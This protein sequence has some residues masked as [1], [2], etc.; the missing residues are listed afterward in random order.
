MRDWPE[1]HGRA[2]L[3]R[4][5]PAAQFAVE[6]THLALVR[7]TLQ[8]AGQC[9]RDGLK[10]GKWQVAGGA[11][12]VR[13]R[14]LAVPSVAR[15]PAEVSQGPLT[16]PLRLLQ[17]EA[18][19]IVAGEG[20]RPVALLG[21]GRSSSSAPQATARPAGDRRLAASRSVTH[22]TRLETRTKESNMC[23]SQWVLNRPRGAM[24]AKAC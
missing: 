6:Q 22:P 2:S 4:G 11:P 7:R 24:K 13:R 16:G 8:P 15:R 9:K 14:L 1:D 3:D 12:S 18:G 21:S 19:E 10:V 17:K 23:A 20:R 5:R